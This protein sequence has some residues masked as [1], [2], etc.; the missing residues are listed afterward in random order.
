MARNGSPSSTKKIIA[1][2]EYSMWQASFPDYS[3]NSATIHC[4]KR[5]A[6]FPSPTGMSLTKLSLD[7]NNLIIPALT[8]L[9]LDGNNLIFYSVPLFENN[10]VFY[11]KNRNAL[12]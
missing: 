5:F 3:Y 11:S 12:R 9:S 10:Y 2:F 7:G 6:I 4:K 8:K 1:L